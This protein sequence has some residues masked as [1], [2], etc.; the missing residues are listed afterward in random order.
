MKKKFAIQTLAIDIAISFFFAAILFLGV[1]LLTKDSINTYAAL[2][3]TTMIKRV[4]EEKEIVYNN[5]AKRILEYPEYGKKYATIK[6]PA[7]NL[8]LPV[9]N[10]D[11]LQI[12]HYG[13]GTYV[14]SYF[15]GE[16]KTTLMA[17]HNNVGYFHDL[18]QLKKGDEIIIEAN[19][20]TFKYRADS[21]LVANYTDT[22]KFLIQDD[23]E[24]L[25]LYTCYPIDGSFG[26]KT[27]RYIVYAFRI[28]DDK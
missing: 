28:E 1:Y 21:F 20:G 10:G 22:E 2:I 5:E 27:E 4:E 12:L 9:Y 3:N 7:I 24:R 23:K 14:G 18:D 19:Y 6:I 17:A 25:I 26:H 15:P 16:G 8:T 11:D 13:V